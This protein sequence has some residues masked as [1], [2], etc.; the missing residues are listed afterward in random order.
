[1]KALKFAGLSLAAALMFGAA[2]AAAQHLLADFGGTWNVTVDGPQGPMN[3]QLTLKQLA[4]SV[5][6]EFESELGKAPV[7][8]K[9]KGDTLWFGFAVDMGGQPLV[10]QGS[11]V[12]SNKTSINGSLDVAG[13]GAFPFRATKK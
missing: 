1:M 10:I 12:L 11:G 2:T 8:G 3:S 6:G 13:M 4:D 7:R 5:S 9:T